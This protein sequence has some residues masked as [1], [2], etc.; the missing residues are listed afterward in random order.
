MLVEEVLMTRLTPGY[1]LPA[2]LDISIEGGRYQGHGSDVGASQP[3]V[4]VLGRGE[5]W[6][7][8]EYISHDGPANNPGE[9]R[10]H[11]DPPHD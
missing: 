3:E 2:V 11:V 8:S 4:P 6:I 7:E 9:D 1:P 5:S 10:R